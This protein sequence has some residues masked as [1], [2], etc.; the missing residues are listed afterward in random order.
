MDFRKPP[1][2][3]ITRPTRRSTAFLALLLAL[4]A[5]LFS[6]CS[7]PYLLHL[8]LGQLRSL[9][10][11]I[12]ADEALRGPL[13]TLEEKEALR[14]VGR[15]KAFGEDRLGLVRTE[16][17]QA[18]DAA[19]S[20]APIYTISAA[21]KTELERVTWWFPV[22]GRM[23]YLGF[24]DL[25]RAMAKKRELEREGLDVVIWAAGAYS[26]LGWFK[27]PIPRNLLKRE[28]FQLVDTVLH[29]MTHATIYVKSRP[30]FNETLANLVGKHGTV[31]FM[32]EVSGRDSPEARAARAALRDQKRFSGFIDELVVKLR[33]L[34]SGP[35]TREEKLIRREV[36]FSE[37]A[38]AFR[39][40]QTSMETGTYSGFAAEG[41]NNASLLGLAL[42]HRRFNLLDSVVEACRGDLREAL[43][44]FRY[45]ART[46]ADPVRGAEAWL[47]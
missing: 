23:P 5:P 4:G 29:E 40:P 30:E 20:R 37:A 21:P 25:E 39:S 26:T 8:A 41:L 17:Y 2:K 45:L 14:L 31:A 16:S 28:D 43:V 46:G 12:P 36:V 35:L 6:G 9:G 22:V 34:Y 13:L 3:W 10:R 47:S 32:E 27:D 19:V 11:S 7:T 42:Y 38:A 18:V 44:V 15:V 1:H 33:R 24:F